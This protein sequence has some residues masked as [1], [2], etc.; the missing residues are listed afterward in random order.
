MKNTLLFI[1]SLLTLSLCAQDIKFDALSNGGG[2]ISNVN[3][4]SFSIGQ[5]FVGTISNG[6]SIRQGFQQPSFTMSV[7][8][9]MDENACNFSFE[10]NVDDGSCVSCEV[11]STACGLGTVWDANADGCTDLNDLLDIL[12]AYGDCAV[13]GYTSCGDDIEHEGYSYSTVQIGEQCWFSEN[14]RYLP[15]VSPSSAGSETSPYYY[16]YGY[17]DTDVAEAKSTANYE[18][19]GVLYNWPAVMTAEICPSGWHVPT[20]GEFTELT[21]FLGGESVAGSAMKSTSG[22]PD[23]NGNSGNGS[24]SSGFTGL[25]GGDRYSSGFNFNYGYVGYWWSSSEFGS[26]SWP[27]VLSHNSDDVFRDYNYQNYGMSARCIK[28]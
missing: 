26:Y 16:V 13:A 21:D 9:C 6:N 25:P 5:P 22:W 18:T 12:S 7:P 4:A 8:G 14:C 19:Y 23:Y 2:R 3:S 11:L 15:V 10:A 20:D 28:D 27:R 24:N 17:E 1:F